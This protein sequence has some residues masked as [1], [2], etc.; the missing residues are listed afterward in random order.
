MKPAILIF[1]FVLASAAIGQDTPTLRVGSKSFTESVLLGELL[2]E[3]AEREG[4][5]V[6]HKASL[7]GTRLVFEA[8]RS[9]AIDAYPE[10]TGT[11]L[12]EIFAD[13]GLSTD[14]ELRAALAEISLAM[15]EP[16]GFNNTYAIGVLPETAERV[17]L[18]TISDLRNA[19]DLRMGFTNEFIERNDGWRALRD[20]YDLPQKDIR[21]IDH[22]LGYRALASGAIDAKEVYTTD[23]KIESMGLAVLEDDLGHF[24]R[25]D[26][27]WIYRADLPERIP[28]AM[29]AIESLIGVLDESAMSGLNAQVEIDGRTEAEVA[30]NFLSAAGATQ[31]SL[32]TGERVRR[33]LAAIPKTT[34][35]HALLVGVSMLLAI[36]IAVPLGV[37]AA[38]SRRF[39]QV[40]L[41]GS[42]ILQ[43]IPSLALLALLVSVLAITG[44]VPTI[45]ALFVYS[46][47]PI[48]RN[49]HTGLTQIPQAVKDSAQ[50]LGLPR[51]RM[52]LDVELPL[53]LPAIFAGIKTA[54]VINV[55]TATLGGF[56]AA[57]GYGDPIL[58]GIRRVDTVLILSG[59]VP[60]ALM[61]VLLTLA[62]DGLERLTSPLSK[63]RHSR[64]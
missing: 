39:E 22:D 8:V 60:A 48:V 52:L 32:G 11:L 56:I 30:R 43:T 10:Y 20:A 26:A 54:V 3:R 5:S 24:P 58:A 51:G 46:L 31:G 55:G 40:V 1:L 4:L 44:P 37:L 33:A 42:G 29:L 38:R 49:T 7:H 36:C 28:Q 2:R 13:R 19:P 17:D 47:L 50:S 34:R 6:E 35:E 27:V 23:A 18:D 21:G 25:Y 45:L 41:G 15:S 62:L 53:A 14:D 57:G 12:R 64:T 16:I 9:G 63:R 61:A 59:L